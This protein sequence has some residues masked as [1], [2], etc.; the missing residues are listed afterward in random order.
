MRAPLTRALA[1][2]VCTLVGS[3]GCTTM[4]TSNTAR[5]GLEQLLISNAIDQSLDKVNFEPFAGHKVFLDESKLESVDKPYLVSSIRTRLMHSGATLVP[6]ADKA[7]VVLEPRSGGVGTDVVDT[8]LGIP[9]IAVPGM[10]IS[11]PELQIIKKQNQSAVAKLGFVAYT[12]G[13]QQAIGQGG[14]TLAKSNDSNW[15]FLGMGPL[16]KGSVRSEVKREVRTKSP[17]AQP[18]PTTIAFASPR[19]PLVPTPTPGTSPFEPSGR[20][21]LTGERQASETSEESP[22]GEIRATGE[23]QSIPE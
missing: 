2:A 5:T 13:E 22:F 6:A 20:V 10:P 15:F 16:Q 4:K 9:E 1:L 14:I 3:V 12:P 11:I 7:E 8:F 17:G 18:L 23:F 19:R 21:R